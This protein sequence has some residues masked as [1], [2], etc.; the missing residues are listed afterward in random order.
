M[1]E[2]QKRE[3]QLRAVSPVFVLVS[4]VLD[5]DARILCGQLSNSRAHKT[6][7]SEGN[8]DCQERGTFTSDYPQSADRHESGAFQQKIEPGFSPKISIC[9]CDLY[10]DF[11]S[12]VPKSPDGIL[13]ICHHPTL[14]SV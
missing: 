11:P 8:T 2:G 12:R 7:P 6:F 1:S 10:V 3:N 5:T 14:A 9:V 13:M 4:S